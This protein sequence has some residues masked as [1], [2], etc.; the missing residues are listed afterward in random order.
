MYEYGKSAGLIRAGWYQGRL[1]SNTTKSILK[2]MSV[3]L[4][5]DKKM[6]SEWEEWV[7]EVLYHTEDQA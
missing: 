2:E 3:D 4:G 6:L 1:R 7:I 5:D